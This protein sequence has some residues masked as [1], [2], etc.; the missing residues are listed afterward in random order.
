MTEVDNSQNHPESIDTPQVLLEHHL[1]ALRLPTILR[2][3]DK[4]AQQRAAED[5]DYLGLRPKRSQSGD[6][7]PQLRITKAGDT[8][9]RKTLVQCAQ[10]ILGPFV[11]IQ[12]FGNG[13]WLYA[14]EEARAPN[15]EQL[16]LWL[17]NCLSCYIGS[18]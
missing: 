1:E 5:I 6:F 11:P 14:Q 7:D 12:Q 13:A 10:Y 16:L 15:E 17:E 18:G 9:L 2:E 8:Y 3:Y 4:V